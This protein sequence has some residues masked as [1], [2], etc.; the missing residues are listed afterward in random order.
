MV[1]CKFAHQRARVRM[2]AHVV[3]FLLLSAR[4]TQ[5][6]KTLKPALGE[7]TRPS[8]KTL[9]PERSRSWSKLWQSMGGRTVRNSMMQNRVAPERRVG[10][11]GREF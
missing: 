9:S 1:R 7:G 2:H 4:G 5:K 8:A 6:H 10:P 11:C 3:L